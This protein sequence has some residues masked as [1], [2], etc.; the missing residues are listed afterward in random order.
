LAEAQTKLEKTGT[1]LE[2]HGFESELD[3]SKSKNKNDAMEWANTLITNGEAYN[4]CEFFEIESDSFF[5]RMAEAYDAQSKNERHDYPGAPP[6]G[7]G[8]L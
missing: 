4:K 6:P 8:R 5:K 2:I 7:A 1:S 3:W